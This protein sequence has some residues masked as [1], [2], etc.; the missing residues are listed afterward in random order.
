MKLK[1]I[2][3]LFCSV[4]LLSSCALTLPYAVT[5][6]TIGTK[7]GV[8]STISIFG[9]PSPATPGYHGLIFNRN[10]GVV[11]AA[12]NGKINKVGSVDLKVT[13]YV[14]FNKQEFIVTGE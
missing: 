12:K 9:R 11:E 8:S 3:I 10:F 6:N 13:T 2:F 5:N 7:T 4:T 1:A 14:L